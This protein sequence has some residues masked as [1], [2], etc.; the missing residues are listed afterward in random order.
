MF[1]NTLYKGPLGESTFS[2]Y[3]TNTLRKWITNCTTKH[4]ECRAHSDFLPTRLVD[5]S[6]SLGA[7]PRLVLSQDLPVARNT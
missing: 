3:S 1:A 5:V 2:D 6:P 7:E 4:K